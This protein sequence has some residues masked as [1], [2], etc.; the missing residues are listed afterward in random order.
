MMKLTELQKKN[1]LIA[2]IIWFWNFGQFLAQCGV[3]HHV[4]AYS[5]SDYGNLATRRPG[6]TYHRYMFIF[7]VGTFLREYSLLFLN[8]NRLS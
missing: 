2:G 1:K 5:C 3:G 7:R 6:A 8:L 4:L